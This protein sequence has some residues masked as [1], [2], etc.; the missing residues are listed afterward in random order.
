V[1][2]AYADQTLILKNIPNSLTNQGT[3]LA[4][5]LPQ[6]TNGLGRVKILSAKGVLVQE[7]SLGLL[8]GG[9]VYYAAW[10][11]RDKNGEDA[12][13]GLYHAV[14]WM[15]GLTST[16]AARITVKKFQSSRRG[17]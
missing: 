2:P 11:G 14:F 8:K 6:G 5:G 1:G 13:P 16:A 3:L 17:L 12:P 9:Y 15:P 4:L 7:L 10:D